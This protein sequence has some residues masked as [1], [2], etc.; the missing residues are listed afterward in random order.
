MRSPLD[1]VAHGTKGL[2]ARDP[3]QSFRFA[4]RAML[5]TSSFLQRPG[6]ARMSITDISKYIP[7][8]TPSDMPCDGF[9]H[10][11]AFGGT[12]SER[13]RPFGRL[14]SFASVSVR[15]DVPLKCAERNL[16]L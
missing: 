5:R 7:L 6:T 8:G 1:T 16:R 13:F 10:L 2:P 4:S 15:D 3:A 12:G 11:T 9:R 14:R